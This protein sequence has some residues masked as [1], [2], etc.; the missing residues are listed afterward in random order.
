KVA[1]TF[2]DAVPRYID[3]LKEIGGKGIDRKECQFDLH[4]KP[5][6]GQKGLSKISTFDIDRYKKHR[7]DEGASRATCNRELAVLSHLFSMGVEWK[8]IS[9][10]PAKINRFKEDT[11]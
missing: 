10:R 4:L 3:K 6:F 7:T 2:S 5:F 11:G 9:H 8:W 1:L